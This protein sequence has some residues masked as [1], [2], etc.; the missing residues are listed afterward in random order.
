MRRLRH[1]IGAVMLAGAALFAC[2]AP[3]APVHRAPP[4]ATA[5]PGAALLQEAVRLEIGDG[6]PADPRRALSLLC[7]AT[8]LGNERAATHLAAWLLDPDGEG[9][10]PLLAKAWLRLSQ[11]QAAHAPWHGLPPRC[12]SDPTSVLPATMAALPA[13][14]A[15]AAG[16]AGL[17]VALVK[18]VI[19]VESGF[20]PDA[21]SIR[22]AAGLMQLMPAT[23]ARL[24]VLDRFDLRENLRGG[25]TYL[26]A[27]L[28]RY[29]GDLA[30]ALAAYNAG[31][32]P[33]DECRCVPAIEE[34]RAY[35]SRVLAV[36]GS[37]IYAGPAFAGPDYAGAQ[38]P[39]TLPGSP[40]GPVRPRP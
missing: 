4:A 11:R 20:H 27:L 21:V 36:Y 5:P 16:A 2:V 10:D 31:S 29:H 13:L 17:D 7:R 15:G 23:A 30:L 14:I 22:G 25:T 18:A 9:Y 38:P 26:A 19:Q 1:M 32:G 24:G 3:A 40:A 37:P 33:V 6:V 8:L 28:D 12:P 34:T 35:V 39:A